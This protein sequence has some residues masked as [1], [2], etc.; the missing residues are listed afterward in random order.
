MRNAGT[1]GRRS[2]VGWNWKNSMSAISRAGAIGQRDAVAGGDFGVRRDLVELAR[3]AGRQ[4]D[5][6]RLEALA[7]RRS[8]RRA[9]GRR[10]P[11]PSSVENLLDLA[12]LAHGHG[13]HARQAAQRQLDVLAGRVA[14][15]VE[16]AGAAVG[17][18]A[19]EL[20]VALA[21]VERHAEAHE[22]GDALRRLARQDARRLFVDQAGAGGKRVLQVQLRRV[23]RPDG[24]GDAALGVLRVALVDGVLGE[25]EDAAVLLGEQGGEQPGNARADDDVV[26]AASLS[27]LQPGASNSSS[28][29]SSGAAAMM[30]FT[31]PKSLIALA[32]L[33]RPSPPWTRPALR[34]RPSGCP[35]DARCP[36]RRPAAAGRRS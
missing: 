36:I 2:A 16:D 25:D 17:A 1:P 3:A 33:E 8:A 11:T 27:R 23:V 21:A 7:R 6:A 35:G 20:D 34:G 13:R 12:V 26:V 19:A 18:F 14:A 10:R 31:L 4:D 30:N 32:K 15:G 22:V 28:S 24:R 9:P 29:T 5:E